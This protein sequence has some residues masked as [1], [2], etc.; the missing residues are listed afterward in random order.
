LGEEGRVLLDIMPAAASNR[1]LLLLTNSAFIPY[2]SRYEEETLL[3]QMS[4]EASRDPRSRC[5]AF[6][7]VDVYELASI[8]LALTRRAQI[9]VD[10]AS[11]WGGAV[12]S[13]PDSLERV[14]KDEKLSRELQSVPDF[15]TMIDHTWPIKAIK[16]HEYKAVIVV[17]SYGAM[18]D[19]PHCEQVIR[20]LQKIYFE[21]DGYICTIGHGAA[22]LA[23][24]CSHTSS[25]TSGKENYLISNKKIACPTDREEK[26]K[27]VDRLL[28][29][30]VEEKLK[31]RGARIQE[32]DP[33]K[34]NVV[35]DE[36]LITAQNAASVRD[37]IRK[38]GEKALNKSIEV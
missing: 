33:F 12:P 21:N 2:K 28:P 25:Q 10:W 32:S 35:I 30:S 20:C 1:V 26:E 37:F 5:K 38:I 27:R 15:I 24:V 7:G 8:W 11:P 13:D 16:P 31:Q 29:F 3:T 14:M 19:L 4:P 36:R 18:F 23:N 22:V 9:Q 34:P 6:T 17:G